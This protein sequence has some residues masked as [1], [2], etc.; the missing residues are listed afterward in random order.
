M[1]VKN[2]PHTVFKRECR[3]NLIGKPL[4]SA[5]PDNFTTIIYLYI[6]TQVSCTVVSMSG[7]Q[8]EATSE[9]IGSV[10]TEPISPVRRSPTSGGPTKWTETMTCSS[11]RFAG[12]VRFRTATTSSRRRRSSTN[13][14]ETISSLATS[15]GPL[16]AGLLVLA[17]QQQRRI[18]SQASSLGQ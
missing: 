2:D 12:I 3:L 17:V 1:R 13:Q 6:L 10:G 11:L 18:G 5:C 8:P 7:V 9:S 15:V 14:I 4:F 16:A